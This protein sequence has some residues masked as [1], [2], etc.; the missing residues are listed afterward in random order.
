MQST[1]PAEPNR[2]RPVLSQAA[3]A[4]AAAPNCPDALAHAIASALPELGDFGYFDVVEGAH[5]RRT[6]RAH[7]D[8]P[9][10]ALLQATEWVQQP[11]GALPPCALCSGEP[12]LYVNTHDAGWHALNGGQ[13]VPTYPFAFGSVVSVPMRYRGELVGALTLFMGRSGRIHTAE[14]L[15]LAQE[16]ATL[17]ALI[18]VNGRLIEQHLQARQALQKSEEFLRSA[19]E[20]GELGLWEWDIPNDRITCSDRL[21]ALHGLPPRSPAESAAD[22]VALVHP[23]DLP[24]LIARREAA[25]A[26]SCN[27]IVEFRP[28]R[29]DGRECWLSASAQ[30]VRDPAGRPLRMVGA[31]LDVTHRVEL[32]AAERRARAEA[33]SARQRLELVAAASARLSGSLQPDA[34]L[35]AIA[36]LVVPRL[37]DWCR[38]DLLDAAGALVRTVT[39]HRDPERARVGT[40]AAQ[41]LRASPQTMGSLAWCV[42]TGRSHWRNAASPHDFADTGDADL[43]AFAKVFGMRAYCVV[44]LVARGRRIGAMA[45]LQ[46]ESGRQFGD[47][48]ASLIEVLAQRAAVALDNA[49]LYAEAEEARRDAEKA[50]RAKDE[51]MAMLGHELRNPLAPIVTMLKVM[52]LSDDVSFR[53]ERRVIERQVANLS[54]LVDDLLDVAR[55]TG[56]EVRL[57]RERVLLRDV[58]DKAVETATPLFES[59]RHR[60]DIALPQG[61]AAQVVFDADEGRLAQVFANLLTN[62]ARYTP[63]GGIVRLQAEVDGPVC[64]IGV[65]DNGQGIAAD[66]LP[67]IFELF[68]QAA[69][70]PDR[71]AGGLGIGLALVKNL[72]GLHGG[73]VVA[74]SEGRGRGSSFVVELPLAL[75]A[76]PA[77][78]TAPAH[79]AAAPAPRR[80]RV[81]LVD[82]NRDALESLAMML[83]LHGHD[84][85]SAHDPTVGLT[86]AAGFNPD[87]AIL[88]IGLP[89][90]DGYELAARLRADGA[91]CRL[92]ALT[93]YG[94]ADDRAKCLAAGFDQH[95]VKPIDPVLLIQALG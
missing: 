50:N 38:V 59:R 1:S 91:R 77:L 89:G 19:T 3:Q 34:T 62:A 71:A 64:R 15:L 54:R 53:H 11:P 14:Q 12:A 80:Q 58:I 85:R 68:F 47:D 87:V 78:A 95:L 57:K 36:D 7:D 61:A 23:D 82:D 10:Q 32:L 93:G 41:R 25:L 9:L 44:P 94:G 63:E 56:G 90:M 31:T 86:L 26:G 52:A 39:H 43:L 8:A 28:L 45:L 83:E 24:A 88:D 4:L 20:A 48:D 40:E 6:A 75:S 22:F 65:H 81:L 13:T 67:H 79:A 49:R 60:L 92:V 29:P 51:F 66:V 21:L 46:A 72:V 35:A 76:L 69:Q 73:S 30:V 74:R 5:V 84:V 16:L 55:I 17:A 18:V 42:A 2:Q 37:A 70:G 27:Y 33:E